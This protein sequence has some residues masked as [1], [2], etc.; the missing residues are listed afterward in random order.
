MFIRNSNLAGQLFYLAVLSS[1]G[2]E[3]RIDNPGCSDQGLL[4]SARSLGQ[5][6]R[7]FH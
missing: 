3:E 4:R 6:S 7:K 1:F 5:K 2:I